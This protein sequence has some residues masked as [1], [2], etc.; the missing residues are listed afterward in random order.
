[1][2][3]FVN[4]ILKSEATVTAAGTADSKDKLLIGATTQ[5][6]S[7]NAANQFHGAVDEL[8]VFH[9]ALSQTQIGKLYSPAPVMDLRFEE[10][11]DGGW[12]ANIADPANPGSCTGSACPQVGEGI[13]GQVGLAARFDGQDDAIGLNNFGSFTQA[14]VSA[15]VKRTGAN[16]GRE[17]V[18]SYK[19]DANCGFILSLNEDGT[20]QYP[21]FA[22]QVKSAGGG[23]S[24][25]YAEAPSPIPM[26]T[27]VHLAG[28]YDGQSIQL[29]ENGA[30]VHK[31]NAVG[32]MLNCQLTGVATS[33]GSQSSTGQ[34]AFPGL[35]D[36]VQ[37]F[38]HA[39]TAT[40]IHEAYVYENG[41]V[42]DRQSRNLTI[43]N[44]DPTAE[45]VMEGSR[46]LANTPTEVL[47]RAHDQTSGIAAAELCQDGFCYGI[48]AEKC[49]GRE[50]EDAWC[51]TYT[52]KAH[53]PR[54]SRGVTS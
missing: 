40:D 2:Q 10:S 1:M 17:T 29:F 27:W 24:W 33:V 12:F 19:G 16:S 49:L 3:F 47:I 42:E 41:W 36:Q 14:T 18:I 4:D 51:P 5:A 34:H 11:Q 9:T 38:D 43:D 21:R 35:I 30:Q 25:Q 53:L 46:Y 39:R 15:W 26:D 8:A 31:T 37:V 6:G 22:V 7:D 28:V 13:K 32:S 23:T 54:A 45:V 20:S 50:S 44:D 48:P 52:P